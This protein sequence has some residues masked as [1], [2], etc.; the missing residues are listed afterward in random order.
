MDLSLCKTCVKNEIGFCTLIFEEQN[1]PP[2]S[3]NSS[4]FGHNM[5]SK[6]ISKQDI[7]RKCAFKDFFK[8]PKFSANFPKIAPDLFHGDM[9]WYDMISW[10]YQ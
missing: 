10:M 1:F 4:F 6:N 8:F 5:F 3:K 2:V 7:S 9:I